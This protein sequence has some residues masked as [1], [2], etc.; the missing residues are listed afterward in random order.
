MIRAALKKREQ[1]QRDA[2][3]ARAQVEYSEWFL[4]LATRGRPQLLNGPREVID[5]SFSFGARNKD[6]GSALDVE[7]SKGLGAQNILE[8]HTAT[9][10][11]AKLGKTALDFTAARGSGGGL[12]V[13]PKPSELVPGRRDVLTSRQ[14]GRKVGRA[15]LGLPE[16]P[17][18]KSGH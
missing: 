3:S 7:R 17:R 13:F 12:D 16:E 8:R 18:G 9:S 6:T 1:E 11:L 14:E 10:L 4:R 15:S 2:A 5:I